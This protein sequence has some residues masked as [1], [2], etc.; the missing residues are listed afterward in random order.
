[1]AGNLGLALPPAGVIQSGRQ[2]GVTTLPRQR[3]EIVADDLRRRIGAGEFP[4]DR[5]GRRKLPSRA[6]LGT[7]YA[8]SDTV[9]DKAMM[10]LRMEGLTETLPGVGVFVRKPPGGGTGRRARVIRSRG[11]SVE[12]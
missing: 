5:D 7:Y 4:P 11:E 1:M 8:A 10:L 9:I 12:E 2:Q 6:E 3:Y